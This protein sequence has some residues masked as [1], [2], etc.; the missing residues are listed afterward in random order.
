MMHLKTVNFTTKNADMAIALER[1]PS[2][3]LPFHV[4]G[5]DFTATPEVGALASVTNPDLLT[6]AL[7]TAGL[8][9][10]RDTR[11]ERLAA[12]CACILNT[13]TRPPERKITVVG[14]KLNGACRARRFNKRFSTLL[15]TMVPTGIAPLRPV[16]DRLKDIAT[17]EAGF[18]LISH[19]LIIPYLCLNADYS[20]M[21]NRRVNGE[22]PTLAELFA[23]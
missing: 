20:A 13:V 1:L 14:T 4:V 11:S 6:P 2:R 15:A 9:A 17:R 21:A 3:R 16:A 5:S 19:A 10:G 8:I 23:D 7:A 22:T 12:D 18:R